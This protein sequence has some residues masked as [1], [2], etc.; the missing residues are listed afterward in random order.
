M[1]QELE[2]REYRKWMDV[3]ETRTG[4]ERARGAT[5]PVTDDQHPDPQVMRSAPSRTFDRIV[6]FGVSF[7]EAKWV[8]PQA[9]I[10]FHHGLHETAGAFGGRV[11]LLL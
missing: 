4:V 5:E 6:R 3:Q 11:P 7:A 10:P 8:C 9:E 1:Q 2:H